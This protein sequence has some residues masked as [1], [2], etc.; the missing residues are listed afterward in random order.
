V[1]ITKLRV[2]PVEL[3]LSSVSSHAVR[4][5]R[6]SQ[7]ARARHIERVVSCRDVTSQVELDLPQS[8]FSQLPVCW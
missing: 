4:Q 8:V 3:V 1:I 6:H 5:S 7:N 2:A